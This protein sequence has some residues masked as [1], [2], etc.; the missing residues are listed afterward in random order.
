M[1]QNALSTVSKAKLLN[2]SI[3]YYII[4]VVR[5]RDSATDEND[6]LTCFSSSLLKGRNIEANE[7]FSE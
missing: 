5:V 7:A 1:N 4:K 2:I 3:L 6:F